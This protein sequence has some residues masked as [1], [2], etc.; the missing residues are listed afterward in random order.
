MGYV[1]TSEGEVMSSFRLLL[2]TLCTP[3]TAGG[4]FRERMEPVFGFSHHR[5]LGDLG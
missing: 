3:M 4:N 5:A 1:V 2:G